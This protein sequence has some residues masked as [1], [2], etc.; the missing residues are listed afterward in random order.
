MN[1]RVLTRWSLAAALL[2]LLALCGCTQQAQI[3]D[4]AALAPEI[5]AQ[6]QIPDALADSLGESIQ[7]IGKLSQ[8]ADSTL[9]VEQVLGNQRELYVL[10]RLTFA[11]GDAAGAPDAM[12]VS[13]VT[14]SGTTGSILPLA[15]GNQT[16]TYLSYF[17]GPDQGWPEG[18]LRFTLR[19]GLSQD[20]HELSW[21][22]TVQ[23]EILSG[24]LPGQ[25]GQPLAT[26]SLSPFSLRFTVTQTQQTDAAALLDTIALVDQT[27][28]AT[29]P[30]GGRGASTASQGFSGSIDFA[31]LLDPATIAAVEIDGHTLPLP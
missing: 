23:G 8:G 25:D 27:G 21:T 24:S 10:Y 14:L 30:K 7:P 22:S 5:I 28:T 3:E 11:R 4:D 9:E 12:P 2:C 16:G 19:S 26:V 1:R 20:V 17:E 29:Q 31:S 15:Q 6:L 18:E 13:S